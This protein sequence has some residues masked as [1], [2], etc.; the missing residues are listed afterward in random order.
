MIPGRRLLQIFLTG[1]C[2][3]YLQAN[4]QLPLSFYTVYTPAAEH[5]Q[6]KDTADFHLDV[7][8]FYISHLQLLDSEAVVYDDPGIY[9]L[10]LKEKNPSAILLNCPKTIHFTAVKFGLG[11]DSI[12]TM[13]GTYTGALDPVNGMYWTWNSGFI[14]LKLEGVIQSTAFTYHLGGYRYP[15]NAYRNILLPVN[16]SAELKILADPEKLLAAIPAGF[17]HHIMSPSATA[18]ELLAKADSIFSFAP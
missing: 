6:K 8:K 16:G 11:I 9:L 14:N 4:G 1:L 18:I 15:Y 2:F 17:P 13:N 3:M 10:D 12:T 5:A 7:F